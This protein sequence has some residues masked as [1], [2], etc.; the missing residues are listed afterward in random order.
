M[1]DQIHDLSN[2]KLSHTVHVNASPETVYHMVSDLPRMGEWSPA[3]KQ[4]VWDEGAGPTVGSW[5]TGTNVM[6]D[7]QWQT[8]SEVIAAEPGKELAWIVG[9]K[10]AGTTHWRYTFTPKENGTDIE[11]SWRLVRLNE[12]LS[13]LTQEGLEGLK[14]R[15]SKS[16]LDTLQNLKA[17]VEAP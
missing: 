6:P 10:D 4:V 9:G 15:T 8:R 3:C 14:E 5:F 13:T 11:E 12:R 1:T 7:R 17:A 2:M 16:I